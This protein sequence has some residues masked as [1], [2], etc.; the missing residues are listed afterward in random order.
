[1]IPFNKDQQTKIRALFKTEA[2]KSL[3]DDFKKI[4]VASDN[5]PANAND[6]MLF[7]ILTGRKEGELSI[8]KQ[9]IKIGESN[10]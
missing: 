9:L 10:D 7:A 5:Y 3:L 6:G 8:L 4:I 1:M 2:G